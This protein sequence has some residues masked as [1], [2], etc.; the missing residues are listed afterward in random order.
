MYTD[1]LIETPGTDHDTNLTEL[2]TALSHAGHTLDGIAD[3][4]LDRA[5]PSGN[6]GD[7]TALLLLR[8]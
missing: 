6:Q 3:A 8:S 7:D 1:G 5:H 4:L 2:V